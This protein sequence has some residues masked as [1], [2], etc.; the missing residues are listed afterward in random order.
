M[1]Q[2]AAAAV[3]VL[4]LATSCGGSTAGHGHGH[5]R[6]HGDRVPHP[7]LSAAQYAAML[8]DPE[9]DAWQMPE[10]L[11]R[12]LGI[13]R[14]MTVADLGCG[15][16]Y[17]LPYLHAAVAPDGHVL[18]EDIDAELLAIAH[19]KVE[20]QGLT[21]VTLR[22]GLPA[23]PRLEAGR[24]DFVLLVDTYHHILDRPTFLGHVRRSL[25]PQTGRFVVVDFREDATRGP[26]RQHRIPRAD[27][28]R[29]LGQAGMRLDRELT[30]LPHQFVLVFAASST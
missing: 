19:Q 4:A 20:Q 2:S 24:Y 13:S 18:G 9:R 15:S 14:G 28:I 26:P 10:R 12:E 3:V 6:G 11:V 1:K 27:V 29:E 23:D 8:D 16:G 21:T 5:H 7:E 22:E 17:F 25:R 30:F